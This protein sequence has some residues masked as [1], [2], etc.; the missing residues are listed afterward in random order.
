MEGE[1]G[2]IDLGP[3]FVTSLRLRA[4]DAATRRKEGRA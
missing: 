3:I 4:G 2:L 1:E